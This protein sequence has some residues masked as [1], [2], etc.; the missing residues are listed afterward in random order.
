MRAQ[1]LHSLQ[2]RPLQVDVW[3]GDSGFALG[4]VAVSGMARLV[5]QGHATVYFYD[6][7]PFA[8]PLAPPGEKETKGNS[9][10]RVL[11]S[12]AAATKEVQVRG[13]ER[14]ASVAFRII[15]CAH[16]PAL[17]AH[18][19]SAGWGGG[20]I[21][22]HKQCEGGTSPA[23]VPFKARNSDGDAR[24]VGG[25]S[26]SVPESQRLREDARGVVESLLKLAQGAAGGFSGWHRVHPDQRDLPQVAPLP[27]REAAR[28]H[29]QASNA[30]HMCHECCYR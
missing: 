1:Y 13:L 12:A 9:E 2:T 8:Q 7:C 22:S 29:T 11:A 6:I 24:S 18:A 4:S 21:M 28:P 26:A 23:R 27:P 14:G 10:P 3:D 16:D 19:E 25:G 20:V 5:R 15:S 30:S 17:E